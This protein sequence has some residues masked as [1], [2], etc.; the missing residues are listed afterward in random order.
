MVTENFRDG[1]DMDHSNTERDEFRYQHRGYAKYADIV[2][3]YGWDTLINFYRQ[4]HLNCI[5]EKE[6]IGSFQDVD[7]RTLKLSIAA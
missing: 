2:R 4:Q 5:N 7:D 6:C 1:K 3:L